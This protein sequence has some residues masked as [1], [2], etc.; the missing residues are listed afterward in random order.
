MYRTYCSY[1]SKLHDNF[2]CIFVPFVYYVCKVKQL[3]YFFI[4]NW[5]F[6]DILENMVPDLTIF[7]FILKC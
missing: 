5:H 4:N 2:M 1:V 6:D 3:I 7:S